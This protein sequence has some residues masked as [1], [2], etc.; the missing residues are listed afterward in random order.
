MIALLLDIGNSRIKTA[1]GKKNG[2]FYVNSFEYSKEYF[3]RDFLKLL[4]LFGKKINKFCLPEI[5]VI[6]VNNDKIKN[7]IRNNIRNTFEIESLFVNPEIA[8][9]IE[10]DYEKTLGADRICSAAGA[11][12]LF[13]ND[14]NLLVIDYGTATTFNLI[15]KGVFKGGLISPGV[16]TSLRSLVDNSTLPF[17]KLN[18]KSGLISNITIEN[19]KFGVINSAVFT[20]ERVIAE[21][22][23]K[24]KNLFVI[25]TGGFSVIIKKNTKVIDLYSEKL[26]LEGL[27][28]II[29]I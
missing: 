16:G 22:K 25:A 19:I 20:T 6:S 28:K 3:A 7:I 4:I 15:I 21:L 10:I 24:Y 13:G 2:I 18:S 14:K 29:R 1:I 9:P 23:K 12:H 27:N 11:S 8:L 26:V 5:A 17:P